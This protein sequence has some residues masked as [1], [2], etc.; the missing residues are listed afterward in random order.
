[1]ILNVPTGGGK[2]VVCSKIVA[3]TAAKG[4]K[5]M[6]LVY[7]QEILEQFFKTLNYFGI[8]PGLIAPGHPTPF[9]SQV[10]LGMVQTFAR[11]MN[12]IVTK[13]LGVKLTVFDETHR[14]EFEKVGKIL[15]GYILGLSATPKSSG[16]IPLKDYFDEL[17]SPVSMTELLEGGYLVRAKTFSIDH[18][19]SQ[20]KRNAKDYT[21]QSLAQEFSK[22]ILFEGAVNNYL[23]LASGKKTIC[24][25]VNVELSQQITE[26]FNHRGV[27]AVHVDGTTDKGD[28]KRIFKAFA[29][30]HYDVLC[31]V[32]IATTGYDEPRVECIIENRA[33]T[34]LTLHHQMIGRGARSY[35]HGDYTK[36]EFTIIDMGRNFVRHGLFGEEVN[37][38]AIFKDPLKS[39]NKEG[40]REKDLRECKECGAVIKAK[41]SACP[42]CD[43][44][45]TVQEKFEHF[46]ENASL[47]EIKQYRFKNLPPHLRGLKY[48][49]MTFAQLQEYG[50]HMGY[51]P[52]WA[53]TMRSKIQKKAKV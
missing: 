38:K 11:R 36:K 19:F 33:T 10:I 44:E 28:R 30:D 43:A 53:W 4:N 40:K 42:Y 45:Y 18:D 22:P 25:N 50:E 49:E 35:S 7:R 34:Q 32:G 31:N 46:M 14:G 29:N 3:D 20:L 1:M 2:T 41:A 21:E 37:W 17:I 27:K 5:V 52:T 39:Q 24:Y 26:E 47:E 48:S 9:G 8:T 13:Q 15:P 16:K 51:Q 6:I 23:R 12:P